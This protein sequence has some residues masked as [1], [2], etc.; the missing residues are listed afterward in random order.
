M[1]IVAF[2]VIAVIFLILDTL[3]HGVISRSLYQWEMGESLF[4]K[5]T[6]ARRRFLCDLHCR[7]GVTGQRAM[8]GLVNGAVFGIVGYATYDLTNLRHAKRLEHGTRAHRRACRAATAIASAVA[9]AITIRAIP[10]D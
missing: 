3:W 9:I 8:R 6:S 4:S 5:P 2:I 7:P 10:L 1:L